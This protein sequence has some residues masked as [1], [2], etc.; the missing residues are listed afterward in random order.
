M[1]TSPSSGSTG[2]FTSRRERRLWAWTAVAVAAIYATLGLSSTFTDLLSSDDQRA[3]F[4]LLGMALVAATVVTE[5]F[6]VRPRGAEVG[7]ALGVAA[8]V[9][10]FLLRFTLAERTH[11]IEY[12]VVAVFIHQALRERRANGRHVFSPA[13]LAIALATGI[14]ALDEAVQWFVPG[15]VFDPVDV[16]FNCMA[17]VATVSAVEAVAWARRWRGG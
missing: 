17:A 16:W 1:A 11:L 7:I 10:M 8:V 3:V 15:R 13:M 4:F 2:R 6:S 12:G 9:V 5:A 14:G